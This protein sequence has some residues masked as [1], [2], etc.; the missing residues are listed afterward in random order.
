M[1]HSE[2]LL[3]RLGRRSCPTASTSSRT[4]A[5]ATSG[6]PDEPPIRVHCKMTIDGDQ[7]DVRLDA[8]AI[9]R[10]SRPGASPAPRCCRR[11]YDGTMHCFPELAPL[12]HGV[13][14]A[15]EIVSTPGTCVDVQ[16]PTPVTGY[17]SGAYEKVDA[18]TM[19]CWGQALQHVDPRRVHAATVN[20]QN[21]CTGGVHPKT[22]RPFVS[23]LWLEGG[24]GARAYADGNS[25]YM[26]I[27]IGGASNQPNETLERWYPDVLHEAPRPSSTPA[28]TASSAAASASRAASASGATPSSSCSAT[29]SGSARSA[30]PAAPTAAPTWSCSTQGTPEERTSACSPPRRSS[31]RATTC[32]SPPTAAAATGCRGS[33]RSTSV[34]DDVID[35]L[36]S[37]EKARARVR[38][39]DQPRSTRDALVYAVDEDET[40]RLRAELAARDKRP[41]GLAPGEVN[42][43]GEQLFRKPSELYR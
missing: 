27:F 40:A 14:R 8:T 22:G 33:G 42:T 30:S 24:Q 9:R 43:L 26:M 39:R 12:N 16:E 23:Y 11:R 5:T 28:A 17:C 21:F 15:I 1:D 34:L 41:R 10:R 13:V 32:T 3:P 37:I 18:V 35:E 19:A 36:L 4:T 25:F 7:V 2:R 20:L 38:R 31:R 6:T 29:A